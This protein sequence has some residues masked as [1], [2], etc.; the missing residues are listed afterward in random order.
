MRVDPQETVVVFILKV[1][2]VL[3]TAILFIKCE[4]I[5]RM[6]HPP[7]DAEFNPVVEVE[8]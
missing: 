7:S 6:L 2:V 1:L 8:D 5:M 3:T 4:S